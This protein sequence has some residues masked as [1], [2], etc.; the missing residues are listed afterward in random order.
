MSNPR[1][2][3]SRGIIGGISHSVT[4]STLVSGIDKLANTTHHST[5]AFRN[6]NKHTDQPHGIVSILY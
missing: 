3:E 4:P 6:E 5:S 1:E 2:N